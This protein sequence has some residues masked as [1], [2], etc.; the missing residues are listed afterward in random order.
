MSGTSITL[1]RIAAVVATQLAVGETLVRP[2][3]ASRELTDV[4]GAPRWRGVA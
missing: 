3:V 2:P 1:F 4:T